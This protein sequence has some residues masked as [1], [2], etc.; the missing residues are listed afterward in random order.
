[1]IDLEPVNPVETTAEVVCVRREGAYLR[2]SDWCPRTLIL[3]QRHEFPA[4]GLKGVIGSQISHPAVGVSYVI[5]ARLPEPPPT[6]A[7][8]HPVFCREINDWHPKPL[9]PPG[10]VPGPGEELPLESTS[11]LC[12]LIQ[13]VTCEKLSRESLEALAYLVRRAH[14]LGAMGR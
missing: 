10:G 14:G 3:M 8:F 6:F 1:V 9:P 4:S 12:R 5:R 7:A 13:S 11:A 2:L